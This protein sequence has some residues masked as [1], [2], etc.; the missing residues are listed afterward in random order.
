MASFTDAISQFNPYVSQLPIQAMK[1]VGVYKQQKYEEGVQKIQGEID[2]VAGLDVV[3]DVDK[4]Y[5]QSKLNQLGSRLKTVAGGDFSNFQLVN[6]V[7]GMATQIGKDGNIQ[8]AVT[9]TARY[10]KQVGEMEAARKSGKSSPENEYWFS[11][12]VNNWMNDGDVKSQY[13]GRFIEYT[14]VR[15]KLIDLSEKIKEVENLTEN[16]FKRDAN[17]NTIVGKDGKPIIDDAILAVTTKGKSADKLLKMFE[18][19]LDENDKRQLMITANYDY[20]GATKDTF[21][22]DIT[23]TYASNKKILSDETANIAVELQTNKKLSASDKAKLEARLNDINGV[24]KNG[25]LEKKLNDDLSKID[26]ITNLED[27]KYNLYKDKFVSGLAKDL[28]YQSYKYEYKNNPYAQMD[29]Q[30]KDLQFKYDEAARQQ[31]N[32]ETTKSFEMMKFRYTMS[33]DALK[34]AGG[35]PIV[36]DASLSTD[37]NTPTLAGV[38]ADIKGKQ[39]A[40]KQLD[41]SFA[42]MHYEKLDGRAREKAIND[43]VSK[44]NQNP[45]SISDNDEREYLERRRQFDLQIAQKQN[46]YNGVVE[47]SKKF[48]DQ[49]AE[50]LASEQGVNFTNG[51]ALYTAPELFEVSKD[52]EKFYKTSGGQGGSPYAGGKTT[53]DA[54]GLINKYK[55]TKYA[56][57][58]QAYAKHYSGQQLTTTERAIFEKGK[59]ISQKY[60]SALGKTFD[61][62]SKFQSEELARL[63][64]ERQIKVG[65]LDMDNNKIDKA[66]VEQ[67]IGNKF[68]EYASY[69]KGAV[70][71]RNRGDFNPDTINDWRT[72]KGNSGL[73][74]TVEKNYD[75]SANLIIQKGKESQVVPMNATEFSAFFPNYAVSHGLDQ[76]KMATLSSP[77]HTTNVLGTRGQ[78]SGAVNAYF[79]G[80]DIP[81]LRESSIAPTVRLDIEGNPNNDGGAADKYQVRMY[82]YDG[83]VWKTAIL[84]QKGYVTEDGVQAILQNIGNNTVSDVLKS[85]R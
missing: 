82:A 37:I 81:G 44:Y 53:F 2:K 6:S 59:S 55:N 35:Q 49:F 75:G 38:S 69:G 63:M 12:E 24:L 54:Q 47:R 72:G 11:Q 1:E 29:M 50:T 58:A 14:D 32:F 57:I 62:K 26:S 66:R 76:I 31:R 39:D 17:G 18:D 67:L 23:S 73:I 4:Q 22:K 52:V 84:N 41:A 79:S 28:S 42:N 27:F 13:T 30:R 43:L 51:K 5:L 20:R 74:Y 19:G 15:K 34:A 80:Y 8:N 78:A 33:Q 83:Q 56:P 70:D 64:P 21:K 45:N 9:S 68:R 46:L 40:R 3:R 7:G 48:D 71:T 10:R 77:N 65:T 85:N 25:D 16:P 61:E 36:T 60:S